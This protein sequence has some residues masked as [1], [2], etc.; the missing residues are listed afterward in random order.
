MAVISTE[1]V[2]YCTPWGNAPLLNLGAQ[3]PIRDLCTGSDTFSAY[4]LSAE[5]V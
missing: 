2:T 1:A 4:L 3:D 5:E